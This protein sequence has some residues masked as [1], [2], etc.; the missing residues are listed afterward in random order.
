[1]I[2]TIEHLG[3]NLKTSDRVVL[4]TE[5]VTFLTRQK[6]ILL[7]DECFDMKKSI[8]LAILFLLQE[9]FSIL[10]IIARKK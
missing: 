3:V 10:N 9:M 6:Q 1:M 2:H 8:L 5:L 4:F 7:K